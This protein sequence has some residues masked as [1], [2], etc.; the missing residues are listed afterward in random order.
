MSET[1]IS[2]G[3]PLIETYTYDDQTLIAV[4]LGPDADPVVDVVDETAI[5]V[6]NDN[7]WEIDV[8]ENSVQAVNS[9][10]ILTFKV[11]E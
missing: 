11:P 7:Q 10:G 1:L 8:P 2:A 5:I 3:E 6:L 4:D 9:N